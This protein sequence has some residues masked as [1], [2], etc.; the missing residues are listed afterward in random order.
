MNELE[1][2]K[3]NLKFIILAG[4]LTAIFSN[5]P[6][7]NYIFYP[8]KM[9]V[10]YL[11]EASHGLMAIATGGSINS[12][13]MQTDTSGLTYSTGGIRILII[14]AGYLG[15]SFWGA[16]LLMASFEKNIEKKVL[17][18]LSL[19]FFIFTFAFARNF[20]SIFSG[21]F[22]GFSMLILKKIKYTPFL[23]T[24]LAF[25]SVQCCFQSFKDIIDLVILSK[26]NIRTDAVSMS[27]EISNGVIP[28]IVFALLWGAVSLAF[29]IFALKISLKRNKQSKF[30][31]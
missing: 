22:F 31:L 2:S 10:T 25:L 3:N 5:L 24:F 19:F 20:V 13:T 9:F 4:I 18:A 26:Y 6:V 28:P 30:E 27:Y 14:S 15:S 12:F 17:T 8:F 16:L 11:H 1:K 7:G 29:F 21:L 23:T